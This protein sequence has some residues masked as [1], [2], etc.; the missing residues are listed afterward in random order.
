MATGATAMSDVRVSDDTL[1]QFKE[2]FVLA[3]NL[4]QN[5]EIRISLDTLAKKTGLSR[6]S[7]VKAINQLEEEGWLRKESSPSRR[8]ANRY[9]ILGN[10]AERAH[11]TDDVERLREAYER[12][13][14]EH[15]ELQRRYD[16]DTRRS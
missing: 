5:S 15:Q 1:D 6:A 8:F 16:R 7:V 13:L 4:H 10:V 3:Y 2:R 9:V 14:R 11:K 12:L